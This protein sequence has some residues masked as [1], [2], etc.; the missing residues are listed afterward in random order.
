MRL[1]V[2]VSALEKLQQGREI[3]LTYCVVV[4]DDVYVTL[5][6]LLYL[7]YSANLGLL[8]MPHPGMGPLV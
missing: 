8:C 6:R 5:R 1:H 3:L 4:V 7:A 2:H